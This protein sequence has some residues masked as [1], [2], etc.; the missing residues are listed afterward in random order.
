MVP[1]VHFVNFPLPQT[2][3]TH[4]HIQTRSQ[5]RVKDHTRAEGLRL[6]DLMMDGQFSHSGKSSTS[7]EVKLQLR[8]FCF[9]ITEIEQP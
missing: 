6:L 8:V 4:T 1:A 5:M 9:P 7:P 3:D 2:H